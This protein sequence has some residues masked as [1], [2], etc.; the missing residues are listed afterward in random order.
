MKEGCA[1]ERGR[2]ANGEKKRITD[3]RADCGVAP[4]I[5]E[6][7]DAAHTDSRR[8]GDPLAFVNERVAV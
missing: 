6:R 5:R 4:H 2:S 1:C 8:G 7:K 3:E